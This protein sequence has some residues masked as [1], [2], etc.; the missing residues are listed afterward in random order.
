MVAHSA[1]LHSGLRPNND[2]G[3]SLGEAEGEYRPIHRLAV[4]TAGAEGS[5]IDELERGV[6]E[7]P[8]DKVGSNHRSTRR[9][10]NRRISARLGRC[11]EG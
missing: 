2:I 1:R 7:A 10:S 3:R 9:N 6:M 11:W 4:H 5:A 8:A